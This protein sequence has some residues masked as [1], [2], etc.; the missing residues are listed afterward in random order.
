[1]QSQADDVDSAPPR[2][3]RILIVDDDQVVAGMLGVALTAAGHT[4]TEAGSG[5]EAL[6]LLADPGAGMPPDIL[7]LDIE[8]GAGMDGYETC[9]RLRAADATRDIPVIFLSSHDGLEDR[10]HAYDAG[11]S[12]FMAKPFVADE[13]ARK[14]FLAIRHKR[15]LDATAAEVR[16]S[17]DTAVTALACLSDSEVSLKFSRGALGCRT[18]RTLAQLTI[19][20][21]AAL[22]VCCHVQLRVSSA[23]LTLTPRG[24]ASPL[25]E[26]VFEKSKAMDRVFGFGNRLIVNYDSV[27]VLITN[28]PV[29]DEVLCGRI[30]D[31]AATIAGAAEL[32]VGNIDLRNEA[33]LRAKKLRQLADAS[34]HSVEELRG[35]YREMQVAT[36]M[37]LENMAHAIEGLYVHLGLSNSQ[38]FT[39]SDTV[40]GSIDRVLTLFEVSSELDRNFANIV[41][42]LTSAAAH[43]VAHEEEEGL[44]VEIW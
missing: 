23:V 15:R 30:R 34:R 21:I 6:A 26:S 7:I 13:I 8:M 38:E 32:A 20:S 42:G 5:E 35:I 31:Q 3:G 37:E 33:M 16:S 25:E 14:A 28:M 17:S 24:P 2:K 18:L 41:E 27:S 43:D 4:I 12:D 36:R 19:D 29:A 39:I 22:G 10:L 9:R 11:G 1:M 40:R 44:A